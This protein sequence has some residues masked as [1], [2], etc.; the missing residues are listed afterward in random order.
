MTKTAE[1]TTMAAEPSVKIPAYFGGCNSPLSQPIASLVPRGSGRSHCSHRRERGPLP[2]GAN[3]RRISEPHCGH[4]IALGVCSMR[5]N[6][7]FRNE[8]AS[9]LKIRGGMENPFTL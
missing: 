8:K 2:P 5:W 4:L 1:R 7:H 3:A 9:I 6:S